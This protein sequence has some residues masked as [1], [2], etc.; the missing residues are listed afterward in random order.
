MMEKTVRHFDSFRAKEAAEIEED[1][2]MSPEERIAIV[3]ELRA[4]VYPD[5]AQQGLARVY[6]IIERQRG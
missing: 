5:A 2:E 4:R 1:L 3:L 6:R